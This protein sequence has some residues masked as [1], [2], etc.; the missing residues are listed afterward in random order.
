MHCCST[1]PHFI[2]VGGGSAAFSAAIQAVELGVRVTVINEGLPVGGTCVNVGCVPSKN[3][4]RAAEAYHRARKV[5]FPGIQAEARLQNFSEII[6]QKEELIAHLRQV[7]YVDILK[8]SPDFHLING[9]ARLGDSHTVEVDGKILQGDWIL[10]ATGARPAIPEIPG[11]RQVPFLTNETAY[12]LS[13][14]P[15]SLIILGANSIGLE[16]AQLFAR[17]GSRVTVLELLPRILPGEQ[18]EVSLALLDHLEKEGIKIFT[19]ARTQR[20]VVRDNAVVLEVEMEGGMRTFVAEKLFVAA[21]RTPNTEN[22]GLEKVG[23]TVNKKG[24]IQVDDYL[25]THVPGIFAA[26]DVIGEPMF[27]Y[28]AAYEGK[29]A[30]INAIG[31]ERVKRNYFPLPWVIFTDPQVAGVGWNAVQA[32]ENGWDPETVTLPLSEV[33]RAIAARDT[34]GFIQLIRDGKTDR[35]LGARVVAPEGAELIMTLSVAIKSEWQASQLSDMLFPYLT[36]SEGIKL[37]ALAF[38]KDVRKL[39]C[40]AG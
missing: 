40:C 28:T 17:L 23:V 38:R 24:F 32:K 20:V 12:Q 31:K 27:V 21:G 2:I 11:L 25:Q 37:A 26:G 22:L 16:N 14:L 3:L 30:A 29:L 8:D 15:E 39:S 36:L 5:P 7:K 6:R 18:P 4:I 9:R 34:R 35:L 19:R 1:K 13:E 33:P 10:L